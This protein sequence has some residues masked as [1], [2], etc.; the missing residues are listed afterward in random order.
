MSTLVTNLVP[1]AERAHLLHH[2]AMSAPSLTAR[3]PN[4]IPSVG[5]LLTAEEVATILRVHPNRVYELASRKAL[6]VV[7]VGR[8]LRFH[9]E[10]LQEWIKS[11][12]TQGA[13]SQC[14]SG[15]L[16]RRGL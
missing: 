12:G 1:A 16:E 13:E 14:A 15:Y 10:T 4:D 9:L 3:T 8:L 6:P 7:R 2:S 11:G 5:C